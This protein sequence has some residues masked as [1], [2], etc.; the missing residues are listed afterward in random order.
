MQVNINQLIKE[1]GVNH[2][3]LPKSNH[4]LIKARVVYRYPPKSSNV[5]KD[6]NNPFAMCI[7]ENSLVWT[8]QPFPTGVNSVSADLQRCFQRLPSERVTV[9]LCRCVTLTRKEAEFCL[10]RSV[11]FKPSKRLKLKCSSSELRS[12]PVFNLCILLSD[13]S[14]TKWKHVDFESFQPSALSNQTPP[15]VQTREWAG[16]WLACL[17]ENGFTFLNNQF[18]CI[19]GGIKQ[20]KVVYCHFKLRG[21]I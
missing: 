3:L 15:N 17:W 11:G 18:L 16:K 13:P 8:A 19:W 1:L 14:K 10:C 12:K 9:G 6:M 2:R 20:F 5:C 7:I 4:K 21:K